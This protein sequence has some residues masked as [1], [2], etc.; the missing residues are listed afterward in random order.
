[1][2]QTPVKPEIIKFP[3][4]E[5]YLKSESDTLYVIN[6]WATWCKPCVKELPY[7]ENLQATYGSKNV[8][9]LLISLDFKRQYETQLIPFIKKHGLKS[10]VMLID[11]IDYDT[12]LGKVDETWSG[13]IPATLF[14]NGKRGIRKFYEQEFTW[15]ELENIIKPLIINKS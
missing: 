14:I 11:E 6:F 4:L 1:M 8:K 15:E 12:W 7:F 3:Q 13:A 9:V 5:R 2:S 10:T